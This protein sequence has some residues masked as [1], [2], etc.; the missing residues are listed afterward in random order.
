MKTASAITMK[1][2]ISQLGE[3]LESNQGAQGWKLSIQTSTLARG[4]TLK[5]VRWIKSMRLL[6]LLSF[7]PCQLFIKFVGME[8]MAMNS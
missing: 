8:R 7:I 2:N 1:K 6:N 4:C 5:D 3:R